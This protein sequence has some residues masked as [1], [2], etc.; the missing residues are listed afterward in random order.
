LESPQ[1]SQAAPAASA[2]NSCE[3]KICARFQIADRGR[4][5]DPWLLQTARWTWQVKLAWQIEGE[6]FAAL[7][8]RAEEEAIKV[9]AR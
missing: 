7:R 2:F 4:A 9:F 1:A 3:R 6:L 5:A 8:E